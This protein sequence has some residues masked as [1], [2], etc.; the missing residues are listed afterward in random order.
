MQTV[1][2]HA[3]VSH[4]LPSR[5]PVV[6]A[7]AALLIG[8]AIATGVWWL[9]DNDVSIL[10]ESEPVT[11]VIVAQPVEPGAGTAAKNEAG[12]AAAVS[13]LAVEP[14]TG[15]AAKDEAGTA[16]AVGSQ[17]GTS[18]YRAEVNPSPDYP[19]YPTPESQNG[20]GARTD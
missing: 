18:Q 5:T 2:T 7:I 1:S 10:P 6:A 4:P 14:T 8:G 16:A 19:A 9:T 20:P 17:Y 13:G 11:R 3:E 12:V 15:T